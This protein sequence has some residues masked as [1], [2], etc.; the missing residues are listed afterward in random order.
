MSSDCSECLA[1]LVQLHD[2]LEKI[3]AQKKGLK[4]LRQKVKTQK[5]RLK[6]AE[7]LIYSQDV[8]ITMLMNMQ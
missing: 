7:N 5:K 1:L 3:Q 6:S 8:L 2:Q 4:R